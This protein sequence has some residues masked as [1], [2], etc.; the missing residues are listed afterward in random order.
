MVL[1]LGL[2]LGNS[3]KGSID[4]VT[5]QYVDLP[6]V[7]AFSDTYVLN[8]AQGPTLEVGET[9]G[10]RDLL[11][12][13]NFDTQLIPNGLNGQTTAYRFK[14]ESDSVRSWI[15]KNGL[16]WGQQGISSLNNSSYCEFYHL[17][18][19]GNSNPAIEG[20]SGIGWLSIDPNTRL[21]RLKCSDIV[22]KD[23]HYAGVLINSGNAGRT[24]DVLDFSF[25]RVFG[26]PNDG[27]GFYIGNTAND[28]SEISDG[29]YV[30]NFV[31]NVG[32]DG[33]QFRNHRSLY[34]DNSTCYDV[35]KANITGQNRLIQVQNCNGHVT[36]CVFYGAPS[37][38]DVFAHGLRF[39]NCYF[40]ITGSIPS[41]IGKLTDHFPGSP[42]ANNQQLLFQNCYFDSDN[43]IDYFSTVEE[44]ECNVT[45]LGCKKTENIG[46]L[47]Q[48][49]RTD[50]ATYNL[51]QVGV[52]NFTPV[53]INFNSL[54]PDNDEAGLIT[55]SFY[56]DLGMGYRSQFVL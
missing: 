43:E 45:F 41:F 47:A 35:G 39:V 13:A 24:Y 51:F 30:N 40:K 28:E 18:I 15:G 56:N 33:M 9:N 52:Q 25:V 27:E 17:G 48:D 37:G 19:Q 42:M 22:I 2:R 31:Y 32:R 38:F 23:V 44:D 29:D 46:A 55:D 34:L 12:P 8:P 4:V 3:R 36:N 53:G 50:K 49:N 10:K 1:G 54:D 5:P 14:S 6:A 16:S 20:I 21:C 26:Y 7:P 11:V